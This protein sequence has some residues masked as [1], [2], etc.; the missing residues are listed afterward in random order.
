M[1]QNCGKSQAFRGARRPSVRPEIGQKQ[2]RGRP[3]KELP[4]I[5]Q[6]IRLNAQECITISYGPS[7][8]KS[9]SLGVWWHAPKFSREVRGKVKKGA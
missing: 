3:R 6:D 2:K 4:Q 8:K 9:I 5:P 7:S 1:D